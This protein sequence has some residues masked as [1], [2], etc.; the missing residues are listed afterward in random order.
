VGLAR[1]LYRDAVGDV[2]DP[3][4]VFVHHFVLVGAEPP[5]CEAIYGDAMLAPVV[6]EAHGEL[7]DA[8]AAR[9]IGSETR[10]PLD[11]GD[12]ADVDDAAVVA[13]DHAAGYRLGY[14]EAATKIGVQNQV[15]VVPGYL[16]GRFADVAARVVDEDVHLAE[17]GF[18]VGGHFLDAGEVANVEFE[19]DGAAAEGF[20]F[21]F[22]W[23]QVIA[24]AAGQDQVGAGFRESAGEVLAE[25]AAGAG[26]DGYLAG[27]VK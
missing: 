4:L 26:D 3:L 9:A 20:D 15:P 6:G 25:A 22:E 17:G 14:E 27:E 7:A 8:A 21:G 18:R 19:G 24:M 2:V 13:P 11:A 10:V 23:G 1:A 12:R 16:E 5:W